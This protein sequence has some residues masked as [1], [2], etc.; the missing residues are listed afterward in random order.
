M[1]GAGVVAVASSTTVSESALISGLQKGD[2][3]EVE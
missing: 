2:V 3:G 1:D